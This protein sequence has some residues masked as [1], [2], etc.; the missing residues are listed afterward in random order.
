MIATRKT[1]RAELQD[2]LDDATRVLARLNIP[3]SEWPAAKAAIFYA[4]RRGRRDGWKA[5]WEGKAQ[6][7]LELDLP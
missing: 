5:C 1:E 4:Y 2:L 6:S 3:K 7:E